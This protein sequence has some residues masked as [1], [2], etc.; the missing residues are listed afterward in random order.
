MCG[1]TLS[2]YP[3]NDFLGWSYCHKS[4]SIQ[5]HHDA[6]LAP[7]PYT[8]RK[9]L[10]QQGLLHSI[11]QVQI[12]MPQ[13][14]W[15]WIWVGIFDIHRCIEITWCLQCVTSNQSDVLK[16]YGLCDVSMLKHQINDN[17]WKSVPSEC[18]FSKAAQIVNKQQNR[19]KG[20][21]LNKLL[22][23]PSLPKEHWK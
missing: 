5:I 3:L 6:G 18:L 2:P 21:C 15:T 8:G 11:V 20:K 7:I 19:L 17:Q 10:P 12:S 16:S 22:F 14:A 13:T 4:V 23:L 9:F 1:S